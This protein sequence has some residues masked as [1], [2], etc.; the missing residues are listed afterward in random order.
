MNARCVADVCRR[1]TTYT[2]VST[3]YF[4]GTWQ[5]MSIALQNSGASVQHRV[6][7][8]LESLLWLLLYLMLR[9]HPHPPWLPTDIQA[10]LCGLFDQSRYDA[11]TTLH[12]G[13][14]NKG[15]FLTGAGFAGFQILAGLKC[16]IAILATL[17][18]LRALFHDFHIIIDNDLLSDRECAERRE[19]QERANAALSTHDRVIAIISEGIEHP[20]WSNPDSDHPDSAADDQIADLVKIIATEHNVAQLASHNSRLQQP[21]ASSTSKA[22]SGSKR[23]TAGGGG[24]KPQKKRKLSS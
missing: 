11:A 18:S 17:K 19:K 15:L 10:M 22:S 13:G 3:R 16:P 23:K 2:N 9:Y 12:I 5:F 7:H 1:D 21:S 8:D 6:P 4:Q 20:G 24:Q 14:D